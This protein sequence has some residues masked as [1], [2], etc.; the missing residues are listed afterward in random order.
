MYNV[1]SETEHVGPVI[2]SEKG[3]VIAIEG[4][5]GKG[6]GADGGQMQQR[7]TNLII[8]V[9]RPQYGEKTEMAKH[10]PAI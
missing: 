4:N 6:S 8:A 5:I 3:E 9:W 2:V 10:T 7:K 1:N